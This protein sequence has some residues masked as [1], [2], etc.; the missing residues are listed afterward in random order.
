MT[1]SDSDTNRGNDD[2]NAG[3]T[4]PVPVRN[5]AFSDGLLKWTQIAANLTIAVGLIVAVLTYLQQTRTAAKNTAEQLLAQFHDERLYDARETLYDL[6]SD[7][8]LSLVGSGLPRET[9]ETLVQKTITAR[10]IPVGKVD[11]AIVQIAEYLDV[12]SVCRKSGACDRTAIDSRL[13]AY[14]HDFFCVYRDR[15]WKQGERRLLPRL[16]SDLAAWVRENGDCR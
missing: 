12:V 5:T 3:L 11:T 2:T 9:I 10:G 14:A 7:Q 8:D 6:W 4:A 15:I 13:G 16:G 1:E